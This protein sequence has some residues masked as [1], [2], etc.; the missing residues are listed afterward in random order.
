MII[1]AGNDLISWSVAAEKPV[2]NE[3]I[4]NHASGGVPMGI[5]RMF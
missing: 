2:E 1:P 5:P 4:R 3:N